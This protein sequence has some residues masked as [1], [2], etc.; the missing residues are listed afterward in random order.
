MTTCGTALWPLPAGSGPAPE[1][2][3]RGERASPG[4]PRAGPWVAA[5]PRRLLVPGAWILLIGPEGR[6]RPIPLRGAGARSPQGRPSRLPS[7]TLRP[8]LSALVVPSLPLPH[9]ISFPI[10]P[11]LTSQPLGLSSPPPPFQ[12]LLPFIS[13]FAVLHLF[14]LLLLLFPK[15]HF[16]A[17]TFW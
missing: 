12:P 4:P 16:D 3:G 13:V 17:S 7:R 14:P 8:P 6:S 10:L 1:A 2:Y 5:A 9:A 11:V 15:C